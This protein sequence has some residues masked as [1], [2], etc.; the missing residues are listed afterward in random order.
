MSFFAAFMG[1]RYLTKRF[2]AHLIVCAGVVC[3]PQL[4]MAQ[5]LPPADQNRLQRSLQREGAAQSQ[6]LQNDRQQARARRT[7]AGRI[8]MPA[9]LLS[10]SEGGPCFDIKRVDVSGFERFGKVADAHSNLIGSCA[11]LADIVRS[12]NAVNAHYKDLGYIT[13]RAYLPKQD[14]SDGTLSIIIIPGLIEGYIYANGKQA[15]ARIKAAFHGKRGDLL[16][17]RDLEQGLEVLNGP[18]S[19]KASFKLIPGEQPG[20]SFI[21]IT[22]TETLPLHGSLKIDNTGFDN[23]GATKASASVGIDNLLNLSDQL[24]LRIGATPFDAREERFS[25]SFS[26]RFSLP[27]Q[28]WLFTFE[29]GASRYFFLLDGTNQNFPVEGQSH[30]LSLSIERLLWRNKLSKHYAYGGI[31]VSRS[32]S[33]IDDF[34]IMSQRRRLSTGSFGLRGETKFGAAQ[35]Q[36][37]VGAKFGLNA[38]GAQISAESI[39]GPQFRLIHGRLDVQKPIS[40]TPLTYS[41]TLFA[42][43]SK[44]VLP[45][46]E[47][48][49]IGGWSTVRG[50]HQD[51][52]Y[53]DV[54][55]Y[56]RN[57]IEWTAIDHADFRLK[58]TGGVDA[59]L[60]KP[61]ELRSWSQDYLIGAHFGAKATFGKKVTLDLQLAH[62]LSRPERNLPNTVSAFEADKTVGFAS[63]NFIF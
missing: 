37:D 28:N 50:F 51:N 35:V 60:I 10:V 46:T 23:T 20:G 52:M 61:S 41:T 15:D 6:Q 26:G 39:V 25:E 54:G 59:G 3:L 48:M 36:W 1:S 43:Y 2:S 9:D 16:N 31:K 42:Q 7:N 34:E 24:S 5:S 32:R 38:F 58:L 63:L 19:S 56:W 4:S 27:Y 13:T 12:L 14:V 18:R 49:S 40:N 45:G 22:L 47:Q 29:G 62:A 53:G 17:L 33:Y 57:S 30:Y 55:A 8:E 44:D 21:Q 11:T